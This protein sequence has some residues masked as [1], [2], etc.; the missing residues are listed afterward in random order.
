MNPDRWE[1][2]NAGFL[3]GQ[4]HLLAGIRRGGGADTGRRT[5][6]SSPSSCADAGG[7]SAVE[8]LRRDQEALKRELA[9]LKRQQEDARATLLDME[10]RMRGTKRRQ[11]Q[12]KAFL[13]R[14]VG[15][16]AFL[17]NLAHRNG[18]AAAA[19][20]VVEGKKKQRLHDAIL[21]PQ[22]ADGLTFEELALAAGIVEAAAPNVTTTNAGGVIMDMIWYELLGEEP[23]DIDVE[24]ED[25]VAPAEDMEPWDRDR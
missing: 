4:R 23:A 16:P 2:A 11:E 12:C 24:V 15:N 13:S 19:A 17:D 14:A 5:V 6:A 25:H 3:S 1:F 7:F 21:S 8:Q 22:P 9:Q 18:F 20:P 10:R